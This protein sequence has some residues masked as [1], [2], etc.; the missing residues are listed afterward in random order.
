M[1][2]LPQFGNLQRFSAKCA[3]NR[4]DNL[5]ISRSEAQSIMLEY[6][7]LLEY[8]VKLQDELVETRNREATEV[9]ILAPKF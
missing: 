5:T 9:E 6:Q 3:A 4:A 1:S 8:V 2:N 7:K